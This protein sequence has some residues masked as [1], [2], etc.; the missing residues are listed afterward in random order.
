VRVAAAAETAAANSEDVPD[1]DDDLPRAT[2]SRSQDGVVPPARASQRPLLKPSVVTVTAQDDK[3]E[4][5]VDGRLEFIRGIGYNPVTLGKPAEVRAAVYDRDFAAMRGLAANTVVGWDEPEFDGVLMDRAAANGLGVILPFNLKPTW[6]YEDSDVRQRLTAELGL[7]VV[8]FKDSPSLRMWGVG[9]EVL[10][11]MTKA[12]SKPAAIAAFA[13]YVIDAAD[14]IHRLDP[15]HPVVYRDAEDVYL[16]PLATALAADRQARPWFVYGMN[17]FTNRLDEALT[18][19]PARTLKQPLLI[20]EFG[21]V[22]LRPSD[23]PAGYVK[24]WNIIKAHND[25][26]LGGCAYVWST[27]GP[28]PLD[29]TFGLTN[30]GTPV[31]GSAAALA[32]QFSTDQAR[33]TATPLK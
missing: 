11:D 30:D 10:H 8:R 13:T 28:E 12:R 9:N 19:G 27:A 15:N 18:K 17:F 6:N 20:S 26:L 2:S 25:T 5:R 29:R 14:L 3:F 32:S 1:S 21:P 24:L 22:G 31:D 4:Y 16:K 7:R 33:E 23:R